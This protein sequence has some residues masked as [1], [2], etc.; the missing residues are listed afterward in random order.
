MKK[1]LIVVSLSLLFI[2]SL[3]LVFAQSTITSC[4]LTAQLLN[5]DP[6]PAVPGEYVK[7]VFQIEGIEN[8]DC[9]DVYFELVPSYPISLDP[10]TNTKVQ[11]KGGTFTSNYQGYLQIPYKVRIDDGALDGDN[12]I[13]VSFSSSD[14]KFSTTEKKFN[15]NIQNPKADFEVFVKNYD[16]QTKVITFQILNIG[17]EDIK[18]LVLEIPDQK[19]ILVQGA[20]MNVVGDLDAQDYTTADFTATPIDGQIKLNIA[21]TDTINI[22]RHNENSVSFASKNFEYTKSTGNSNNK[23]YLVAAAIVLIL[24]VI[25]YIRK[26]KKKPSF[27]R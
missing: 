5:Q 19:T 25:W 27:R 8:P 22:R 10:N 23:Y 2:F 15:I 1:E 18:A 21:Y 3:N 17:K 13:K 20:N 12:E 9:K 6:Y 4:E 16:Y 11:I 7:L 26:R 24:L 14:P